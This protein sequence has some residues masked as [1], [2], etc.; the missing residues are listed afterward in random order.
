[1]K[2]NKQLYNSNDNMIFNLTGC[3]SLCEKYSYTVQQVDSTQ[4][5]NAKDGNSSLILHLYYSSVEHELREQV[6]VLGLLSTTSLETVFF[7]FNIYDT[8]AFIA[9]V[10]GYLGLLLGQ[11]IYGLYEIVT[12][13][14]GYRMHCA[15]GRISGEVKL[16]PDN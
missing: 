7:Q 14:I 16:P 6:N 13:W 1:M 8:N 15:K 11:S 2:I 3:L 12:H 5:N 9:D 4:Y 10:G